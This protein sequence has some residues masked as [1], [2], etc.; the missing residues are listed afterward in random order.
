MGEEFLVSSLPSGEK[1]IYLSQITVHFLILYLLSMLSRYYVNL[2]LSEKSSEET[3]YFYIIE[4]FLDISERK[5]PNMILNEILKVLLWCSC[6]GER[7][8]SCQSLGRAAARGM[9]C[10]GA[11]RAGARPVG[12]AVFSRNPQWYAQIGHS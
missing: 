1:S 12:E 5:F 3:R 2:W 4:K 9:A 8:R 6:F 10:E 7:T 11:D